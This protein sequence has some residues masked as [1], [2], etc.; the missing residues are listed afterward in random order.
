MGVLKASNPHVHVFVHVLNLGAISLYH[1][2]HSVMF[3]LILLPI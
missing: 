2:T 1:I 3:P